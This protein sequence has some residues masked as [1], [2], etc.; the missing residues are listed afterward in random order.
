MYYLSLIAEKVKYYL[1]VIDENNIT[2]NS[3]DFSITEIN[4]LC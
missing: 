2:N 1:S 3:I 4:D